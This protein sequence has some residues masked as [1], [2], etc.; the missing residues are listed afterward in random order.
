MVLADQFKCTRSKCNGE[1]T[2]PMKVVEKGS[3]Y[4]NVARCP[5]CHKE[6]KFYTRLQQKEELLE[7]LKDT[8]YKCDACGA[9]NSGDWAEGDTWEMNRRKIVVRCKSCGRKRA[10]E[11]EEKLLKKVEEGETS[12]ATTEAAEPAEEAP[13]PPPELTKKCPSCG[14]LVEDDHV[15]CAGCGEILLCDKCRAEVKPGA[16]FCQVCGGEIKKKE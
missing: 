12:A 7:F 9:D 15:F 5:N 14:E 4:V 1:I 11:I 6:Y 16:Q 10:K 2:I 13:T 3:E 8:I